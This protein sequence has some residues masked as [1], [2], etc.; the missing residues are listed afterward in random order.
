MSGYTKKDMWK[1]LNTQRDMLVARELRIKELE[2]VIESQRVQ[3]QALIV[4][5]RPVK[6][7]P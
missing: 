6:G 7:K 2:A 1:D 3:L 5:K 4:L